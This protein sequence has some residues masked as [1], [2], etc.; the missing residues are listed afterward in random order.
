MG[1]EK[2]VKRGRVEK[3]EDNFIKTG[4]FQTMNLSGIVPFFCHSREA[5]S[6]VCIICMYIWELPRSPE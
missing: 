1:E 4:L 2:K 6:Q 5:V 3:K